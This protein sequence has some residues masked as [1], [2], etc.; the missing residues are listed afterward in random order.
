MIGFKTSDRKIKRKADFQTHVVATTPQDRSSR[1]RIG[2]YGEKSFP[3]IR[4]VSF[5]GFFTSG[6]CSDLLKVPNYQYATDF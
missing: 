6:R 4:T 2:L 1:C 3:N 5:L